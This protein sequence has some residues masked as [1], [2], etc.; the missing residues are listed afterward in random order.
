[1]LGENILC[2]SL[3]SETKPPAMSRPITDDL[4]KKWVTCKNEFS[5]LFCFLF[6]LGEGA[7]GVIYPEKGGG[8]GGGMEVR[9][10][11]DYIPIATLSPPE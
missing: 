8:G 11:G 3:G 1:M 5:V 9:G 4:F 6:C 2:V 10:E 7:R